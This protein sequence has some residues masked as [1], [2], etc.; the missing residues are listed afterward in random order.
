MQLL[1]YT[2]AVATTH[3]DLASHS[4]G[5]ALLVRTDV[6]REKG[7]NKGAG[8]GGGG[9]GGGG[10]GRGGEGWAKKLTRTCVYQRRVDTVNLYVTFFN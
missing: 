7:S 3:S 1:L 9:G 6:I 10:R 4:G 5:P 2:C 8:R